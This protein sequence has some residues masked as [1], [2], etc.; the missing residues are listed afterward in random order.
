MVTHLSTIPVYGCLT[1]NFTIH[2]HCLD[3]YGAF[4]AIRA[5][6]ILLNIEPQNRNKNIKCENLICGNFHVTFLSSGSKVTQAQPSIA[7]K[8]WL[9][10]QKLLFCI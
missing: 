1:F 8:T 10:L 9:Q 5:A 2:S 4:Y 6:Q 3:S 7:I